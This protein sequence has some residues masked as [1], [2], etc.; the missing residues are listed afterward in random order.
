MESF[1]V[2]DGRDIPH[3]SQ[4]QNL[5]RLAKVVKD[6]NDVHLRK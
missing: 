6:P 5:C 3:L 4:Y 1:D 2:N